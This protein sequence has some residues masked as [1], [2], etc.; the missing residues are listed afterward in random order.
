MPRRN[1]YVPARGWRLSA[2]PVFCFCR[3]S[4]WH[5]YEPSDRTLRTGRNW[6]RYE[7]SD[8]TLRTG[9][10]WHRHERSDRTLPQ[11]GSG[12][13]SPLTWRGFRSSQDLGIFF[14]QLAVEKNVLMTGRCPHSDGARDQSLNSSFEQGLQPKSNGLHIVWND[15]SDLKRSL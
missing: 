13:H 8:R 2:A 5:R 1:Q 7:R 6:H 9:R 11:G 3:P 10:N 4:S 15:K 14:R 12:G